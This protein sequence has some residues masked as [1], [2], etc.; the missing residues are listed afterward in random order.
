M[1]QTH[2]LDLSLA[3]LA[4]GEVLVCAAC[5]VLHRAPGVLQHPTGQGLQRPQR[6]PKYTQV[7]VPS[8]VLQGAEL[9]NLGEQS[10]S[11]LDLPLTRN[12]CEEHQH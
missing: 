10:K 12:R 7:L 6:P 5:P 11:S 9:F 2:C 4:V 1:K 8:K 3:A